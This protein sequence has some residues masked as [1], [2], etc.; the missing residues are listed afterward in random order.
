MAEWLEH[1]RSPKSLLIG[2]NDDRRRLI[3]TII[4]H[5]KQDARILWEDRSSPRVS[6][7]WTPL[8]PLLTE[9]AYIG[10]LDPDAGIEH[11]ATGLLE[12]SLAGKPLKDWKTS[13]LLEYCERYNIGWVVCWS[14]AVRD[15]FKAL[16][17]PQFS[18][19]LVHDEEDGYL[20]AL[21]R[22]EHKPSFALRG[23]AKWVAADSLHIVLEDVCPDKGQVLLSLHYQEGMRVTPSRVQVQRSLDEK[24]RVDFVRLLSDDPFI[25]RVTITWEKR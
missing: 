17:D 8:L 3:E 21:N 12:L 22:T 7:R 9:R 13:E 16:A 5:T 14:P 6:S 4:T 10:G 19:I 18:P 15:Q 2:L 23:S 11:T 25:T 24:D 20:I 1:L